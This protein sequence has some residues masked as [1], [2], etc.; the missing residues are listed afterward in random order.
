MMS[1]VVCPSYGAEHGG[2]EEDIDREIQ[3]ISP[4]QDA[5]NQHTVFLVPSLY[6]IKHPIVGLTQEWFSRLE[7]GVHDRLHTHLPHVLDILLPLA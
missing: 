2:V 7:C 3:T 5:L 6:Y 1:V 4:T